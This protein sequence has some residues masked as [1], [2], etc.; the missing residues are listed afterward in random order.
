MGTLMRASCCLVAWLACSLPLSC[1]AEQDEVP[2]SGDAYTWAEQGYAALAQGRLEQGLVAVE[3]ALQA[4][5]GSRQLGL[6][7]LELLLR[8]Q[9]MAAARQQIDALLQA[10]PGDAQVLAQRGY[11]SQR[12]RRYQDAMNDFYAA[13]SVPGLDAGQQRSA[14]VAWAD[15]ALASGQPGVAVDALRPYRDE[16]DATIQLRL[17]EAYWTQGEREAARRAAVQA[18][19]SARNEEERATALKMLEA[20]RP[21]NDLEQAYAWVRKGNDT[22]AVAAFRHAFAKEVPAAGQYADAAYAARRSGNNVQAVDWFARALDA[23]AQSD[24]PQ[25]D[26]AQR[27]GYRREN[28]EMARRY[29]VVASLAYQANGFGPNNNFNVVQAGLE[30]YWQPEQYGYQDGRVL[31]AFVRGYETLYDASGGGIGRDTIQGSAGVRYKP[32]SGWGLVLSG[33]KLFRIGAQATDDWLFRAAYSLGDGTDINPVRTDWQTWSV[34]TEAAYFVNAARYIHALEAR[35]G[36]TWRLPGGDDRSLLIPHL[37]LVGEHDSRATPQTAVGYGPGISLRHWFREDAH[38]APASWADL[39]L[40]YRFE[41][42]QSNR[43][44][45]LSLRATLWY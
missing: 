36:H 15:A 43:A 3:R 9:D 2:L 24:H 8:K 45:G 32:L 27:F 39:T 23:D 30:G 21:V 17:A 31:Q 7:R 5:P 25:F 34:Y 4:Q 14:R 33:E 38:H 11:L 28:Q 20:T 37:V 42:T 13:L 18:E 22:E 19:L 26:A 40:Q 6:L 12:E 41:M 10:F 16:R 44:H 29:G 1:V 35:Y